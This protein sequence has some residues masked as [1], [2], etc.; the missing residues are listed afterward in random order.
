VAIS[1]DKSLQDLRDLVINE[2]YSRIPVFEDSIDHMVGF[3][4]VRDMFELEPEQRGTT[5]LRSLLR[6]MDGFPESTPVSGVL[7]DMQRRGNHIVY[8]VDEYG[9]TSG[10]ATLEDM[11]EEILGEIRDEHEPTEDVRKAA[12]GSVVVSGSWDLDHLLDLYGFRPSS[13]T[14]ASTIGGLVTEWMGEVP[15]PGDVVEREGL[16]LEVLAASELRVDRVRVRP[17]EGSART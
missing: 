7:R 12:D 8:A 6:P 13:D 2:Q 5:D 3:I 1:A 4:H 16:R 17:T 15:K 14:E 11:V 10:L 9:A